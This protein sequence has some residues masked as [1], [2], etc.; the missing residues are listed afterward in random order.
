M[1][2]L[3]LVGSRIVAPGL[4]V[5]SASAT[6]IMRS[7]ARSLIEPVGLYSSSFAQSR[8]DSLRRQPRQP[9]ERSMTDRLAERGVPDH[10]RSRSAAGDGG[11]HHD[12]VAICSGSLEA[13]AEADILVIDV[14]IDESA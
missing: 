10:E 4:S 7:A 6:L 5:P 2:V 13:A 12:D 3:P 11:Q 8:T 1:P 14:D 9:Y